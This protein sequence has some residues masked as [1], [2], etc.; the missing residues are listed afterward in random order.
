MF[1]YCA[2]LKTNIHTDI[3]TH[4]RTLKFPFKNNIITQKYQKSCI[5]ELS[6]ESFSSFL[7]FVLVRSYELTPCKQLHVESSALCYKQKTETQQ[8]IYTKAGIGNLETILLLPS[9]A[10]FS[11]SGTGVT[12]YK[13]FCEFPVSYFHI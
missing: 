10:Y 8:T 6:L 1:S 3:H 13:R 2:G 12:F 7:F 5:S 4:K 9:Q 11:L